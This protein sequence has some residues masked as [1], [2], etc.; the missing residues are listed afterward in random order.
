M[1]RN[2]LCTYLFHIFVTCKSRFIL[3]FHRSCV[4]WTWLSVASPA[5]AFTL[6]FTILK[7][8]PNSTCGG[9]Y[10]ISCFAVEI[11]FNNIITIHSGKCCKISNVYNS[12]KLIKS[13]N[14]DTP[15]HFCDGKNHSEPHLVIKRTLQL[16]GN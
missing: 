6:V 4:Y 3:I 1:W 11:K 9:A 2:S 7:D 10:C 15:S 13:Y 8:E 16:L 5:D 12:E 14:F